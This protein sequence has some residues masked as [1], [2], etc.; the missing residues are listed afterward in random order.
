ML[1]GSS[2]GFASQFLSEKWEMSV[3]SLPMKYLGL[4]LGASY[5]AT[6]IWNRV[7]EKMECRLPAWKKL[8]LS[9]GGRL[10]LLK[11]TISNLPTYCCANIYLNK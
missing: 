8:Y 9:K 2:F 3:A 4:S 5:K 10:T 7:I 6:A 1:D 11:S